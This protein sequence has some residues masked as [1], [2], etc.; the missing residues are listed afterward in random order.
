MS[1]S[2]LFIA[3]VAL[4]AAV[5]LVAPANAVSAQTTAAPVTGRCYNLTYSQIM[6][7]SSTVPYVHCTD[8]HTTKTFY[9][10]NV[11]STVDYKHITG[12]EFSKVAIQ[13]CQPKFVTT[14]GS[15][16]ENQHL[17]VYDYVFFAPTSAQRAAGARWVRCDLVLWG[18]KSLRALP[19]NST[20][21]IQG[22]ITDTTKR[23]LVTTDHLYTTCAGVHSYRSTTAHTLS[24]TW[25]RTYNQFVAKGAQLCPTAEL[26]TWPSK[27]QWNLG[28]HVLVC[29]DRT[30]A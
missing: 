17:T 3:V 8:K 15:T 27:S 22:E 28:D 10:K 1:R 21:V 25:Y 2:R 11:P 13:I 20:P 12:A 24:G 5:G 30:A 19:T 6:P 14:L 9:V 16:P 23:C 18:G 26:Y 29:Y 7:M 4:A